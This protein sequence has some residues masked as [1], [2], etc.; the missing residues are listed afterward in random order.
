ME[1]KS[2]CSGRSFVSTNVAIPA[3]TTP[4]K[5]TV[6]SPEKEE[7]DASPVAVKQRPSSAAEVKVEVAATKNE[8]VPVKE[9]EP[10]RVKVGSGCGGCG[11]S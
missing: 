3:S 11:G 5:E 7:A 6:V 4:K 1:R 10:V 2:C 8:A 9:E